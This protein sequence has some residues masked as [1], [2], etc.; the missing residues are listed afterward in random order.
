MPDIILTIVFY[1]VA[2]TVVFGLLAAM[3][4]LGVAR[5][6]A[7]HPPSGDEMRYQTK[8]LSP[9]GGARASNGT[10]LFALRPLIRQREGT[11]LGRYF[12]HAA[13]I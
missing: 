3:T 9:E 13:D 5:L 12:G 6:E 11:H 4:I 10:E 8:P 1:F 7:A 2:L